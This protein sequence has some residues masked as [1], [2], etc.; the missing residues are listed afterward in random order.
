MPRGERAAWYLPRRLQSQAMAW[1]KPIGSGIHANDEFCNCLFLERPRPI[2]RA[3]AAGTDHSHRDVASQSVWRHIDQNLDRSIS[4][5]EVA[6]LVHLSEGAFSR[7][8]KSRTGRNFPAFVNEIMTATSADAGQVGEAPVTHD[9]GGMAIEAMVHEDLRAALQRD[10]VVDVERRPVEGHLDA[11]QGKDR[12]DEEEEREEP[13][14]HQVT[15][16]GSGFSLSIAVYQGISPKN[17]K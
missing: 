12:K 16:C 10:L 9:A 8:F 4:V 11:R 3:K 2:E 13:F 14:H 15:R 5:R 7:Y 6:R 1:Q 17:R